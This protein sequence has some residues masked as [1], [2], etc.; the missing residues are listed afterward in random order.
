[1]I[2]WSAQHNEIQ[3]NLLAHVDNI[4]P[5]RSEL[6]ILHEL[7]I[8]LGLDISI[9]VE[10]RAI[11]DLEI[12]SLGKG[13][14]LLCL[15][16]FIRKDASETLAS[17]LINWWKELSPAVSTTAVFRDNAFEDDVTKLNLAATLTQ[18]GLQVIKTI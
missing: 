10:R 2:P 15:A 5:D 6:D 7:I 17:A 16:T 8:K 14:I 11:G 3:E 18:A 9:E 4:R 13:T 12:I 1:V